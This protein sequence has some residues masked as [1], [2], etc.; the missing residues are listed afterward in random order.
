MQQIVLNNQKSLTF[1]FIIWKVCLLITLIK[2]KTVCRYFKFLSKLYS[3]LLTN[4][5]I[6]RELGQGKSDIKC[7]AALGMYSLCMYTTDRSGTL[8]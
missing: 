3:A 1:V 2:Q 6:L 5:K 4:F 7:S 8:G